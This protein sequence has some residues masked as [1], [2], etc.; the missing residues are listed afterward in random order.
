MMSGICR[1]LDELILLDI[2]MKSWKFLVITLPQ[3]FRASLTDKDIIA[4]E[5]PFSMKQTCFHW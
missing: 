3:N 1:G 5:E 4:F 2:S